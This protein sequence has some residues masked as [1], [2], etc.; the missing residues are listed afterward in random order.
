[1]IFGAGFSGEIG[2]YDNDKF[3]NKIDRVRDSAHNMFQFLGLPVAHL[4][5]PDA[6][7]AGVRR[8]CNEIIPA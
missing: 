5:C 8:G 4:S 3:A 7:G 6:S 2:Y 1:V